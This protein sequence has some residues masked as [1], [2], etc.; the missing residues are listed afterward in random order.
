MVSFSPSL[1]RLFIG[2]MK[3]TGHAARGKC[4]ENEENSPVDAKELVPKLCLH[5]DA[6]KAPLCLRKLE[7]LDLESGASH[8][9]R[10]TA[11]LD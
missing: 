10:I 6:A 3:H 11:Q 5:V 8:T 2:R 1:L 4:P 9:P 7:I